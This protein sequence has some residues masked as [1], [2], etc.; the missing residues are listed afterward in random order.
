MPRAR[1]SATSVLF[2][3]PERIETTTSSVSASVTRRPPWTFFG[4]SRAA[5]IASIRLPPP[6]TTIDLFPEVHAVA[7]ASRAEC[8]ELA[9]L[10]EASAQLHDVGHRESLR[11]RQA[12]DPVQVLDRLRGGPLEEVVDGGDDDRPA[13]AGAGASSRRAPAASRRRP[14]AR[15]GARPGW[16]LTN[17]RPA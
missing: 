10:E 5:S 2:T 9:V 7:T 17:G 4:M 6:W 11:L 1:S 8:A 3:S 16:T 14:S 13:A 15:G 12:E